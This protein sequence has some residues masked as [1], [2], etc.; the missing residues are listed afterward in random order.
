MSIIFTIATLVLLIAGCGL[1]YLNWQRPYLQPTTAPKSLTAQF[2]LQ[3]RARQTATAAHPGLKSLFLT[4]QISLW[5]GIVLWLISG[6]LVETKLD[7]LVISAAIS[8][9]SAILMVAGAALLTVYPLVW[10]SASYRYWTNQ[11]ITKQ[12]FVLSD[13]KA[14]RHFQRRQFWGTVTIAVAGLL[15]WTIR[16]LAIGTNPTISIQDLVMALIAGIPVIAL[17]VGLVQLPYLHQNRYL[18][19]TSPEVRLGQQHYQATKT[20]LQHQPALKTK[21]IT[22]HVIRGIGYLLGLISIWILFRNIIAPAFATDLTAVFP[23]AIVALI[24]LC[25]VE[26]VGF[27]WPQRNYGYLR[28]L[29]TTNLPFKIAEPETFHRFKMHL[30]TYHVAAI[31]IWLS[32]WLIILGSYYYLTL[33]AAYSSYAY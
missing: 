4:S 32:I 25:C 3:R 24:G 5:L 28:A 29:D 10:S 6:Y 17:V 8:W 30:R 21:V 2:K 12:P 13:K 14:F 9:T 1:F 22:V 23:A 33:M 15:F 27:F 7:L 20:L 16:I 31:I 19:I 11:S 26:G 18:Q